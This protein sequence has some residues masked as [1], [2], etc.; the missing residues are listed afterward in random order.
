LKINREKL[1]LKA[2]PGNTG[3]ALLNASG[4]IV[5][6]DAS[7]FEDNWIRS[8]WPG[9]MNQRDFPR[10]LHASM[11]DI[12][13][14]EGTRPESFFYH[15]YA[16]GKWF[17][18]APPVWPY[19]LQYRNGG[20]RWLCYCQDTATPNRFYHDPATGSAAVRL[21]RGAQPSI[22]LPAHRQECELG[23][24]YISLRLHL[25]SIPGSKSKLT[26]PGGVHLQN[27]RVRAL[28]LP[29]A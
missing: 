25:V 8:P 7:V 24:F 23:R 6:P 4:G 2:Q 16:F 10:V 29:I 22:P 27:E 3:W 20:S 15:D 14:P 26:S 11:G 9:W 17:W 21:S 18:S 13:V 19:V 28:R 1:G 5:W 12:H